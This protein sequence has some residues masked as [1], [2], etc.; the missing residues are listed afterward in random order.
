MH[1]VLRAAKNVESRNSRISKVSRPGYHNAY[2][3]GVDK[4]WIGWLLLNVRL[5]K[6]FLLEERGTI[7]L[8]LDCIM[9]ILVFGWWGP[10]GEMFL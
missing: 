6:V 2:L 10:L 7:S 4:E 8:G 5:G 3:K 9:V 1:F